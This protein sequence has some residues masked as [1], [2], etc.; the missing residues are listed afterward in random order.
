MRFGDLM[1]KAKQVVDRRGGTEALKKDA[2]EL[3]DIARGPGSTQEKAKRAADA[4]KEPGAP[5]ERRA[6]PGAPGER[7]AES[8]EGGSEANRP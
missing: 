7:R 3:K 2:E 4:I 6:E 5:G 8:R 1:N